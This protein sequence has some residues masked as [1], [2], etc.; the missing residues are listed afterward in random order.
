MVLRI[1]PETTGGSENSLDGCLWLAHRMYS[2]ESVS[3]TSELIIRGNS[4]YA[5]LCLV[6]IYKL[7]SINCNLETLG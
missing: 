1:T 6:K 7:R 2:L 4:A 5:R 3:D